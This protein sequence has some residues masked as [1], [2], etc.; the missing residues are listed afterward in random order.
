MFLPCYD[1]AAHGSESDLY[2]QIIDECVLAESLGFDTAW[3]AEH[4]FHKYG[5][6]VPNVSILLSA[7]AQRTTRLNIAAGGLCVP[8]NSPIRLAEEVAMLDTLSGGR[9]RVGMVRAFLSHEYDAFQVDMAESRARYEE[10]I[11]IM[12]GLW[13]N[14]TFSYD[15]QF[16]KFDEIELLPKCIQKPHPRI[17]V[18]TV[19]SK[20]S[21]EYAAYN[22]FDLMVVP[23][24]FPFEALAEKIGWYTD[25]LKAAGR[26]P[27]DH[28]IM[29]SYYF[30]TNENDEKASEYAREPILGCLEYLADAASPDKWSADYKGYQGMSKIVREMKDYDHLYA[31]NRVMVG[32]TGKLRAHIKALEEVGITEVSIQP[33]LPGISA[34]EAENA[35]KVFAREVMPAFTGAAAAAQ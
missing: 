19:M 28:N 7:I 24:I 5:G 29:T 18:G 20:E 26:D 23:Y 9:M 1:P 14:K 15:G 16:T 22:G 17:T 6:H 21:F 13:S 30:Y 2:N 31:D 25:A 11:E 12:R 27:K 32:P 33:S 35:I 8:L 10:G 34:A 3:V 4:H